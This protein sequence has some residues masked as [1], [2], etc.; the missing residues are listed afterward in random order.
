MNKYTFTTRGREDNSEH[1]LVLD[2]NY[3]VNLLYKLVFGYNQT[4]NLEFF[5]SVFKEFE[6]Y[7]ANKQELNKTGK[8]TIDHYMSIDIG[9][10]LLMEFLCDKFEAK[11]LNV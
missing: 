11:T 4:V 5:H 10:E 9:L 8:W 7:V 3:Q 6:L 1:E 2:L